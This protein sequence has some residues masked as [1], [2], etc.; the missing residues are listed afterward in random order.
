MY[1]NNDLDPDLFN[2][3]PYELQ[4]QIITEQPN[5]MTLF[6]RINNDYNELLERPIYHQLCNK[7]INKHEFNYIND[8]QPIVGSVYKKYLNYNHNQITKI[9]NLVVITQNNLVGS[10]HKMIE[11]ILNL[12]TI[13]I[14]EIPS[15]LYEEKFKF[16]GQG[17]KD[18]LSLYNVYT[19]RLNCIKMNPHY[20]KTQIMAI[21][22]KQ[23]DIYKT[24]KDKKINFAYKSLMITIYCNMIMHKYIFN[25]IDQSNIIKLTDIE[26]HMDDIINDID[27]MQE[28]IYKKLL[29][30][31]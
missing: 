28:A 25:I 10:S 8:F 13:T 9:G 26:H 17:N 22:N 27:Y 15:Q 18:L 20:A 4:Q 2:V 5:L 14:K 16:Y 3:L 1:S 24:L 12:N 19:R 11:V 6:S 29:Y 7:A 30:L 31:D 21:F 23:R